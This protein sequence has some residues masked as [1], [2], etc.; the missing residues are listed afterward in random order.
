MPVI[1][2]SMDN[3]APDMTSPDARLTTLC[4]ASKMPMTMFHVLETIST[5]AAVLN[6]HL[7]MM[8]VS[9]S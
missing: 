6:T 3:C 7:K 9:K 5:D 4:A 2:L 1:A 8:N